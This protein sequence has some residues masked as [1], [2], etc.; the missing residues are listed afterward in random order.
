MTNLLHLLLLEDRPSDAELMLAELRAAGFELDWKRVDSE[1]DYLAALNSSLDLIL[2][3]YHLPQFDGVRALKLMRERGLD[4]PFILVSGTVGEDIAVQAMRD[5]AADYL[6]KD[7]MARLGQAVTHALEDKKLRDNEHRAH[8]L[9]RASEERYRILAEAAQDMIIV[10]NRQWQVEYINTFAAL[11]VGVS[12]EELLAKQLTEIF[13]PEIASRQQAN[14]QKVFESGQL[15]YIEAPSIFRGKTIWLGTWLV[16]NKDQNGQANTIL[17]VSRNITERRLAEES[18]RDSQAQLAGIFNSAM[19]AIITIDEEQC[20]VIFNPAAEQMFGC[21]ASDAVGGTLDRFIPEYYR[22]RHKESV[23]AF[24][25]SN[26]TTRNMEAPALALVCLR[27]NGEAFPSEVSISRQELG[28][29]KLYTAIVRDVTE[30][31][32]AEEILRESED[33]YRDLV[34]NSQDLICTHDLEGMILSANPASARMLGYELNELIGSNLRDHLVPE[35]RSHFKYYINRLK[36]NGSASGLLNIQTKGGERRVWEYQ[37]TIRTEGVAQPIVRG[38]ARDITERKRAEDEL[39]KSEEKYRFLFENN[40]HPM[41]AYDLKTLAFLAV[42]D[43]AVAKYGY[44]RAEFLRMTI[45]DIRPAEDVPQLMKHLAKQRPSLLHAGEWRHRL[46]DGT[47][48]DVEIT[49]HTLRM[50]EFDA[51]LIVAQDVTERKRAEEA[52]RIAEANYRSI[53][54]NAPV[55]FF[56]T[57]RQGRFLKVN[58]TMARING[59]ASPE[60]MENS[61][62]DIGSQVYA[63]P[64]DRVEFI[65]QMN[66]HGEVR[67]FVNQ[68]RRKDGSFIWVSTNARAVMDEEGRFLYYEGFLTDVTERKQAEEA[69]KR[70]EQKYRSIFENATEGI[71]QTTPDG[72][73][74]SVNPSAARMF[75]FDS[76]AEMIASVNDINARF[77]VEPGRRA[78]FKRLMATY[79]A[80]SNFVSEMYCKD[81]ST[82]WISENAHT[83]RDEHGTLL[84]FEGTSVNIT[85]RKQAADALRE[86]EARYRHIFDGV[87]DAIFVE[88]IDGR[89]LAVNQRACDIYGYSRA[90]FLAKTVED[91]VPQGQQI[92]TVDNGLVSKPMETVNR[93][94]NGEVFPIEISGRVET[95]NGEVVLLVVV[96]DISERKQAEA[97]LR[98]Q[99]AALEAAVNSI[100]ITDRQGAI[101]WA[102]SAYSNLTGFALEEVLG[103]NP[104]I[105]DSGLQDRE[106]YKTMW[107]IIL[108]GQAWHGEMINKRKDGSLYNEEMTITPLFGENGEITHFIGI[109]QDITERKKVEAEMR[110]R[111]RELE[112]V[113]RISITLRASTNQEQALAIMLEEIL[114]VFDTRHGAISLWNPET[115]WLNQVIARGWPAG[116]AERPIQSGEGILGTVFAEGESHYSVEFASDPLALPQ[117]R[118]LLP[119]GWGGVCVPI[120]TSETILGVLTVTAPSQRVFHHEDIRLLETLAEMAGTALHRMSLNEDVRRH[121]ERLQSLR[122]IDVAIASNFDRRATLQTILTQVISQLEVSAAD[123]LMLDPKTQTLHLG[124]YQGFTKPV[125][126]IVFVPIGKSFAGMAVAEKRMISADLPAVRR[127][128]EFYKLWKREGFSNSYAIPL[129]AKDR[130][131]GVLEVYQRIPSLPNK[132]WFNFFETLAGQAAIA[133][134]NAELFEN[135]ETANAEL[136]HAYDATIEG[137]SH[138]MDLRDKET[139]GHTLRV[140]D[141]TLRLTRIMGASPAELVHIRRGALLHDIGKMGIPDRI[142]L[143]PDQLTEEEWEIMRKHPTLALEMLEPIG[144]LRPA[145]NIPYSHHEKWDGTGYPRGLAGEQIPLEARIFAV[146][147]VW[148]AL[149]SDRPYRLAWSKEKALNY[150]K[151]QSGKHFDPDVVYIFL[152]LSDEERGIELQSGA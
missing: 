61:V 43:S 97:S 98:L 145:L 130:P 100:V 77:Y 152:R 25:H 146:V 29:K 82:I 120:R 135:L 14:L 53:L 19:D 143:K 55:G 142:L 11:Q 104:R 59:Y 117:S 74:I 91:L 92:V 54:E 73:I 7:R 18:L 56:Q 38:M 137:W 8:E 116:I 23:Q 136:T 132:E 58:P 12:P 101:L 75:G 65:R 86:S 94:A 71:H 40:P 80:V 128:P 68:N 85:E 28:G 109:K 49:S 119:L 141:L 46:K 125:D 102:N 83:V 20:V 62:T 30:R 148:D 140:T 5:G 79:G 35:V 47:V 76:P 17:I 151:E 115:Q 107:D 121:L 111:V 26:S 88:S 33:R 10:V 118:P 2:A 96:R 36:R 24:G 126:E 13:P 70:A 87:Q 133:L 105:L 22:D 51:A 103:K 93:R 124:A 112:T 6:L 57:T 106:F 90:E 9:L 131:I 21:P 1:A 150:I 144:Y 15:A 81:G 66:E 37:N 110:Q 34:E 123:V 114:N 84:Y 139:E 44:T 3:D 39:H 134:E 67:E 99:S 122:Q 108:S 52:Q 45:A 149:T 138:A 113:N 72:K 42:N 60:E 64:A 147:D 48:I 69:L 16:P 4:I 95:I 27:A 78:E 63:D 129:M 50:D 31:K 41:W 127:V 32:Q 89:I